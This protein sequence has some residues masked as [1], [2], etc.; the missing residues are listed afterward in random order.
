[1]KNDSDLMLSCHKATTDEQFKFDFES[2]IKD[3]IMKQTK[4]STII[5]FL[6]LFLSSCQEKTKV[7]VTIEWVEIT[8]IVLWVILGLL[9]GVVVLL[10]IFRNTGKWGN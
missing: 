3:L 7:E 1:M 4:T 2:F 8:K 10:Y 6:L 9:V 5:Y